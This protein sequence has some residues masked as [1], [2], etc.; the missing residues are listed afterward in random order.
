MPA[1]AAAAWGLTVL[2]VLPPG[3]HKPGEIKEAEYRHLV[4]VLD[5]SRSMEVADAGPGGK[6]KRAERA[7]D[8]IQSFF[9]RVQAERYKT[10]VIAVA[11][12]AK[13]V[14]LD[15]TD[16]EVVRNVLTEL[17][18]RH[19]FKAG[20]TNMF[21]GIE[22]A[23]KV[24][25]PWPPGSA[26]LMV[27]T[28]GDTVP[29]TGMPKMPASIGNNVVMVGVGNPTVGTALGGHNTRQDVS[30]L[31]QV[32]TRLNGTYHDGN[33]KQLTTA[34]ISQLDEKAK[35]KGGDKWTAREYA[36]L[37]VGSGAA[38]CALLPALLTLLGTGWEPGRR[39]GFDR[40]TR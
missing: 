32:A 36:L 20:E 24:A 25:K 27:V 19:A 26:V 4:L 13:P 35:P 2:L 31:R 3:S 21:A 5:V 8:L 22:E 30:T 38:A 10:T 28:D 9:E 17:P 18:M 1:L 15:T 40:R 7:A 37:C 11:S 23:V 29:T 39:P 33:E 16:R 34:L 14:V 12:E 6:Q